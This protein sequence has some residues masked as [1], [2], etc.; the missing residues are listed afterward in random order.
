MKKFKTVPIVILAF[1]TLSI[2]FYF[3]PTNGLASKIP[4]LNRFYTNTTLEVI[5]IKGK[6]KVSIDGEEY[7]ET[8]VTINELTPGD[9][10]VELERISDSKDF[11][12]P[13]TITVKLTKN[14]TSR[15]EIEI[16]PAG[17]LH[18]AILY[19]SPQNSLDENMGALSILSEIENSKVYLDGEYIKKTPI[20]SEKLIAKEYELEVTA[21][22]FETVKIPIL[23]EE[24]NLLNVKTYLF[25][26]P[27]NFDTVDNG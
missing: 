21:D 7:G 18:G 23:I 5:A 11:Y 20:I 14:T 6:A 1:I 24:G 10:T 17:I 22:G 13:Q 4:F 8:P 9:Y 27:I 26:I 16:G 3:L 12:K 25:P 2:L 15:I 19:Y